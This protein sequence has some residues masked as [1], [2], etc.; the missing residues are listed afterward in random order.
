MTNYDVVKKLIGEIEPIGE[1]NIDN[2]RLKNLEAMCELMNEIHTA[3][4]DIS[5]K[6]RNS[7]EFS[8][9]RASEF[10][11]NIVNKKHADV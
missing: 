10:A 9:K 2:E 8:I 5:Y 1:T 4:E 3:I 11:R 6:Y 7:Q